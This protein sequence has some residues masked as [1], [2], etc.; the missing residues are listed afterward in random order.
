[1]D[2]FLFPVLF[3]LVLC[4]AFVWLA[5]K[6][7]R[8]GKPHR[9]FVWLA[10]F[11]GV[12]DVMG[13]DNICKD[14]GI[15]L[16]GL[17]V[18]AGAVMVLMIVS[19]VIRELG[20]RKKGSTSPSQSEVTEAP[21]KEEVPVQQEDEENQAVECVVHSNHSI[22]KILGFLI[23]EGLLF[24]LCAHYWIG[25]MHPDRYDYW[26]AA[27]LCVCAGILIL[28]IIKYISNTI[29]TG[30]H[31]YKK[32]LPEKALA[33]FVI[34]LLLLAGWVVVM[35]YGMYFFSRGETFCEMLEYL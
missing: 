14:E 34:A 5:V 17:V 15:I 2:T 31:F 3:C 1:M 20:A 23:G 11:F 6:R 26:S 32:E 29:K 21:K 35:N 19:G 10:R 22:L 12:M 24:F 8:A 4:T 30:I 27:W 33:C 9:V 18:V 28:Y 7:M 13:I 16:G 25:H